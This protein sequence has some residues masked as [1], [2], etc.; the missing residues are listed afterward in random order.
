MSPKV[1]TVNIDRIR[2]SGPW[3]AWWAMFAVALA[4]V[5]QIRGAK[6]AGE[7][8]VI[9][10][11]ELRSE[12][13]QAREAMHVLDVRVSTLEEWKRSKTATGKGWGE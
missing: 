11:K 3:A 6:S 2:L 10:V 5:W 13:K 1:E 9:E 4:G 12:M 7:Q 8:V